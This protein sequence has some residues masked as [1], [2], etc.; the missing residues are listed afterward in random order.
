MPGAGGHLGGAG[1]WPGG[2]AGGRPGGGAAH[3]A[4]APAACNETL[5]LRRAGAFG[6]G[7]FC[8]SNKNSFVYKYVGF[9][10]P[11]WY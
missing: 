7:L 5:L 6:Q 2:G 3:P 9:L 1:G 4:G 11:F 8:P 10:R